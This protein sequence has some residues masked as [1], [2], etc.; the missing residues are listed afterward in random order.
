M[1]FKI[2]KK[3][4]KLLPERYGM[5]DKVFM[6]FK[7]DNNQNKKLKYWAL[8]AGITKEDITSH[9]A[10]HSFA[11]Y[12]LSKGTPIYTLSRLM[13]HNSVR[14]TERHYAQYAKEDLNKALNLVFD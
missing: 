11:V 6:G 14:T 3:A 9:T 7:Y 5:N 2:P 10:R 1:S 13:A 8:K 12:H 4:L